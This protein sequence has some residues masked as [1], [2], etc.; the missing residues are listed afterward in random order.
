VDTTVE[1]TLLV[2]SE[3]SRPRRA[4]PRL[5]A[6]RA[7]ALG[8]PT[9]GTT[10]ANRLRRMDNWIAATLGPLLRRADDPLVVDLGYGATPVTAVELSSRLRRIRDDV[11]VVGVEIDRDRVTAAQPAQAPPWLSFVHGGFEFAGLRP[12]LVRA[13][14]V[15]RQYDEDAAA[16]AW[17]TMQRGLAPGGVIVEGTCDEL[18]RLAGWVLLDERAPVSLT[19]ACRVENLSRPSELA[20]RLPK[21]LIHHNVPG[22]PIHALLRDFDAAWEAAAPLSAFGARQ[23]WTGACRALSEEWP[24]RIARARHGELTVDWS[25]VAPGVN[26]AP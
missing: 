11:R 13:A 5:A 22:E 1:V 17:R 18:G 19:L 26:R 8:L 20:E 3:P 15:L 23:R 10:N 24:V 14:N 12:A 9:R 6:G 7:R 21:S 4:H 16:E 25:A 2:V